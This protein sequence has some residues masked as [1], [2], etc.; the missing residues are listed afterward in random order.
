[1]ANLITASRLLLLPFFVACVR[2]AE[3]DPIWGWA[4]GVL[5]GLASASD[6]IDGRVARHLGTAGNRGRW[7]DHLTDITFLLVAMGTYTAIGI[8]P[9]WVPSAVACSFAFYVT[10]SVLRTTAAP[11]LIASRLGHF[12]G[13]ANYALIGILAFNYSAAIRLLP[14]PL[15]FALYCL[16]PLYSFGSIAARLAERG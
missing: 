3:S 11:S 15:M 1:M 14:D 9:W 13:I 5:F 10:D 6:M 12:G 2:F 4:A 16:V 7:F 8:L